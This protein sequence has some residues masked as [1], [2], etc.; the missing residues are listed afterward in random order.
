MQNKYCQI[1]DLGEINEVAVE[2]LN[3]FK[4]HKV[5]VFEAEMGSGKTTLIL[6]IL[7]VMGID[8]AEGSPTY[9]LIN[10]YE[11]ERFG[12]VNH[13]DLYRLRSLEEAFDIGIEELLYN[14]QNYCFIEWPKKVEQ[15]LPKETIWVYLSPTDDGKR[16]IEVK[17]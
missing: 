1:F 4:E 8:S 9:S 15:L 7:K 12:V 5:W 13:F 11:T 17:I 14:N 10:T 16:L 6:E 3:S 2:L